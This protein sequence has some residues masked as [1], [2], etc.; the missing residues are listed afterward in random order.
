MATLA[1][2]STVSVYCPL[3]GTMTVTPGTSGRVSINAR[4]RDGSQ[5]LA[6]RELYT[7]ETLSVTAGDVV[8]LEAINV[9]ATYT[10]P[11]ESGPA[12]QSL[13]SGGGISGNSQASFAILG[14]SLSG[15]CFGA[16]TVTSATA[17]GGVVT[18]AATS[19]GMVNGCTYAHYGANEDAFNVSGATITRIDANSFSYS[20]PGAT[21]TATGSQ[22][23]ANLQNLSQRGYMSWARMLSANRP[24]IVYAGVQGGATAATIGTKYV[25]A[26]IASG[27]KNAVVLAGVNNAASAQTAAQ[28]AAEIIASLVEPLVTQG[29]RVFLMAVWPFSSSHASFATAAPKIPAIN[30]TLR[31]YALGK[32]GVVWVDGFSA[33]ID[34]LNAT[35]GN[36]LSGT[37]DSSNLHTSAKGAYLA[38]AKLAAAI[39]A[40]PIPAVDLLVQ[41]NIDQRGSNANS[42]NLLDCGLMQGAAG[43]NNTITGTTL[44]TGWTGTISG[45]A[46]ASAAVT[47]RSDGYGSDIVLTITP[48]AANAQVLL[49]SQTGQLLGR[50]TAGGWYQLGVEVTATGVSASN[51]SNVTAYLQ[52]NLDGVAYTLGVANGFTSDTA[53]TQDLAALPLVSQPFYI[54]AGVTISAPL[55]NVT[56]RFSA[57]SASALT[58]KW[59][60]ATFRQLA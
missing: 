19:H 49:N 2:G 39:A 11:A 28:V 45:T 38:G 51:L 16:V 55:M 60:R 5:S 48:G 54:P 10:D 21:G 3:T 27:A 42:N 24:Q 53:A 4:G 34:P 7:A 46:T 47:A 18:V 44:P 41:A 17:S 52:V 59:G 57:T 35:A 36:A 50:V 8:S 30:E 23:G 6:P 13:V 20:A 15:Y 12:L 9:A 25:S 43:T 32:A 29:V 37:M 33:L 31:R 1:A 58:L 22:F 40:Q 26:A 56:C 14:D